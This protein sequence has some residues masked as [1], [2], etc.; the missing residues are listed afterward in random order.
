MIWAVP[1]RANVGLS[2]PVSFRGSIK[3]RFPKLWRQIFFE[4]VPDKIS[5]VGNKRKPLV[6]KSAQSVHTFK[7]REISRKWCVEI[8][9]FQFACSLCHNLSL[10]LCRGL[11]LSWQRGKGSFCSS[12]V[13]IASKL[14]TTKLRSSTT[15]LSACFSICDLSPDRLSLMISIIVIRSS[16]VV[17]LLA[18]GLLVQS[19]QYH[20]IWSLSIIQAYCSALT[21]KHPMRDLKRQSSHYTSLSSSPYFLLHYW[22]DAS[23]LISPGCLPEPVPSLLLVCLAWHLC[24]LPSLCLCQSSCIEETVLIYV[25]IRI[26]H[27]PEL[28]IRR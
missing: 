4:S 25:S 5:V 8:I 23:P 18:L 10:H 9:F 17:L 15:Y 16:F 26:H 2:W 22:H 19:E 14:S 24:I 11:W 13:T 1:I 3:D 12:V 6:W 20:F 28:V 7:F 27:L 21:S